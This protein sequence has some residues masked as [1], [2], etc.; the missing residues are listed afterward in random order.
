MSGCGLWKLSRP[1][2]ADEMV[3]TDCFSGE[4]YSDICGFGKEC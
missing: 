2:D 1:H 4:E 3:C